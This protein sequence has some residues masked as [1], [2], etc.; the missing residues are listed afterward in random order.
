MRLCNANFR[1][2]PG[3]PAWTGGIANQNRG[4]LGGNIVNASP[5]ADSLP[6]LLAYEAELILVSVRGERRVPY[7]EFHTGYKKTKLA[8]DELIRTDLPCPA[9]FGI[10]LPTRAKLERAMRRRF[11]KSALRRW[12][13]R[14]WWRGRRCPYRCW[15]VLRRCRFVWWKRNDCVM[16]KKIEPSL[17]ALAKK[18]A[19]SGN[20]GRSTIF[21]PPQDIGRR[22]RAIWSQNFLRSWAAGEPHRHER[23]VLARWNRLSRE[24]AAKEILPCCGSKAWAGGDGGAK[25][26]CG[27]HY[28]ASSVRRNLE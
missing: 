11:P 23:K 4:T 3:L 6:A 12:A 14:A 13:G 5:A 15:E 20:S 19:I 1:C 9:I 18:T 27:R 8:P 10:S 16:G 22:W 21:D 25:A 24:D 28:S 26:V 17:L 2:W 7:R